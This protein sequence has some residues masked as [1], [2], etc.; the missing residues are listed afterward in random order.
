VNGELK[1]AITSLQAAAQL[2]PGDQGIRDDLAA[3]LHRDAQP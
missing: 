3:A 2:N 1:S